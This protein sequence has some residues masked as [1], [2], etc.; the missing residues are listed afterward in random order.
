MRP[1]VHLAVRTAYSLRDGVI[2]PE[3]LAAAVADRG[4][5]AVGVADHDG[6][7]GAVRLAR[8]CAARG[9]RPILGASLALAEER[10]RPGWAAARHGRVRPAGAPRPRSGAAWLEG[11][12]PRVVLLARSAAGYAALARFVSAVHHDGGRGRP[13]ARWARLVEAVEAAPDGLF[14]L[15]GDD[16]PVA[17]LLDAGRAQAARAEAGRWR[18]L[19]GTGG[20]LVGLT[21]HLARGDDARVRARCALADDVGLR[22]VVHQDVRYLDPDDAVVADLADAIRGQVPLAARHSQRR[23]NAEGHLATPGVLARRFAE[24]P[25]ALEATAWVAERCEVDLGLGR[26]RVP[27]LADAGEVTGGAAVELR[28]R[29]EAGLAERHPG[30][31]DDLARRLDDELAM[32]TTLGLEPY[33][34][35]VAEIVDRIRA[36]GVMVACRGSAAGSLVAHCLRISDVDP[37]RHD[38]CFERFC[39]PYRDELPDI[40]LDVESARRG[41]IYDDLLT[42]YGGERVA[43]VAMVETFKARMAV[44]EVG[45][46]LG[47]PPGEVDHVA[48]A[49]PRIGAADVRTAIDVLPE[50]AGRGLDRPHLAQLLDLVGRL[51]GLPRHLALHPSGVLLGHGPAEGSAGPS[52]GE[53][54]ALRD[55]VPVEPSAEGYAMAQFDKDDVEALGLCKL[56]VLSVRMLSA[57]RHAVDEAQRV[58][59]SEVDLEAI[60]EADPAT[61]DLIRSTRTIGMFQIES[62]GQRELLGRLQPDRVDDLVVDI[63]LFR[64]GPVKGDMIGPF[65]LRRLGRAEAV[66]P[67]PLLTSALSETFGVIVYHEQVMRCIAAL[68]GCDLGV[69]DLARRRLGDPDEVDGLRR[70]VLAGAAERGVGQAEAASLWRALEQFASFGF[71]KAHA[72]AFS[73]PTLRSAWLKAHHAPELVA[74]LLTHDPGMYPRR[75]ILADARALG[76]GVLPVDVDRSERDYRVEAVPATLA[77]RLL[78]ADGPG[79]PP[80]W[81]RG[82]DGEPVPPAGR[83]LGADPADPTRRFAIRL[84]LGD[85]AGIDGGMLDALVLGRPFRDLAD[86]RER[87]GLSRPVAEAL[88]RI[89]ALDDLAGVA[90]TPRSPT[91][92]DVLLEVA[93]RWGGA[94]RRRVAGSQA[95]TQL[96]LL[97]PAPPPGLAPYRPAEQVRAELEVLGLDASAH[98]VSFYD[99]LLDVLGVTR[100]CDLLD[101]ADGDRVR[102]AGA[103]VATQTPPVRSGQRVIFLSLDDGTGVGDAAFFEDAQRRCAATVLHGWLLVVEGRVQRRGAR[104]VGVTAEAAWDLTALMRA[105]QEGA[106]EAAL[107]PPGSR[108]EG[109]RVRAVPARADAADP[110]HPAYDATRLAQAAGRRPSSRHRGQDDLARSLPRLWHASEGS[111]G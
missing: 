102:L 98:V 78:G 60:D 59:G 23:G 107:A 40:D 50:L 48:R 96:D 41:E 67:H 81:R 45:K 34:L 54:L 16:G 4:M 84:A 28:R 71:C 47:L 68:T 49:L 29:C 63:S 55:L 2:R 20:V 9:V 26:L 7:Y 14:A 72:A 31:G 53:L 106:L 93:E 83:D 39:N 105:W 21:H 89:G 108:A 3:A 110:G 36:K 100:A 19:L 15:L 42:T 95:P 69:A 91:R 73:V 88:A 38:L 103:K 51:D 97:G 11:D 1:F 5:E 90:A 18:E 86:L 24:R 35:T 57:M 12:A 13:E 82:D 101:H 61:Y 75:L 70:W 46:A 77:W 109:G 94:P 111:A 56:D 17:R 58:R 104:G 64:P 80:G 62:P 33:F 85:V 25:D 43:C 92:R 30:G 37:V 22:L 44:R 8:A 10:D 76:I 99:A 87:G 65:L 52:G 6:L 32:L 27:D 66:L 79:L 74:G